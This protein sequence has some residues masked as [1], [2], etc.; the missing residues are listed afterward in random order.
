[1]KTEA[2]FSSL[3][4]MYRDV[5]LAGDGRTAWDSGWTPNT[6]VD[7][8]RALV[9][10]FLRN[11]ASAG[12]QFLAVGQG[13]PQWDAAGTPPPEATATDLLNRHAPPIPAA[14]LNLAYLDAAGN[15]VEG[16]TTRLQITATL[17]A[18]YPAIS[19]P[20]TAYPLREFG[21]FGRFGDTDY[22]VNC[23]RHA[24][25]HKDAASTLIRVIRL[26]F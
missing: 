16:P 9:A 13:L 10:G 17:A 26:Y 20:A 18:G 19:P 7:R 25:I 24:V 11:D 8:G 15:V 6:V 1:M 4:G 3:R 22:M 21:L 14:D 12:I 23:V 5:L 2:Q